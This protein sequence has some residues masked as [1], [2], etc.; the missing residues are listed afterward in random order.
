MTMNR[1][2]AMFQNARQAKRTAFIPFLSAGDPTLAISLA[3]IDAVLDEAATAGVPTALEIGFPYSDPIADG[4]TIQASYNRALAA[5]IRVDDIFS[6]IGEL[7]KRRGEPMVSMISFSLVEKM[8]VERF[9]ASALQAGLDGAIVPDLPIEETAALTAVAKASNFRLVPT[10]APT[11]PKARRATIAA[12]AGGFIY[13][14]SVAGVT[15]ERQTLPPG[16]L[17]AVAEL[18]KIAS[19]PVCVGFGIGKPE[20]VAALAGEVDGVIVGSALVRRVGELTSA[21]NESLAPI[22]QFVRDL[23]APLACT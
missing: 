22:R 21:T 14:V 11:T 6:A 23:I 2:D 1:L 3:T 12:G 9:V 17:A 10:V 5:G 4:P 7:R 15:G 8:G 13:Y 20:H 18:R 16:L 19:V